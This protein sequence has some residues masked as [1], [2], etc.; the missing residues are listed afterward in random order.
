MPTAMKQGLQ[1]FLEGQKVLSPLPRM[2][3][4][5]KGTSTTY[6]FFDILGVMDGRLT[7]A[8]PDASPSLI[9]YGIVSTE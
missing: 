3:I 1:S 2:A 9:K 4:Y 8:V 7:L 5:D 6:Y